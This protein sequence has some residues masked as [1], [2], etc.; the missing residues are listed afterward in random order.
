MQIF[1]KIIKVDR[2]T[3][4]YGWEV[5]IDHGYNYI[6]KYAHM[7]KIDV[8]VGEKVKRGQII[9]E[10]G[11]TGTST[12]PHLHYEVIYKGKKVNPVHYFF[13]DLSPAQ[14]DEITKQA[15]IENQSFDGH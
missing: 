10:V 14:Y 1:E 4:G 3:R 5:D 9:G 13:N 8:R 6:T 11:S 12:A 15:A 2:K 7:S